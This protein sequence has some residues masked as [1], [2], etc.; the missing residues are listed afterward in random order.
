M[1][2]VEAERS[3]GLSS[4]DQIFNMEFLIEIGVKSEGRNKASLLGV[5][6]DKASLVTELRKTRR[7]YGG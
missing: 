3:V 5:H 6:F 7:R 4:K 1:A 2:V